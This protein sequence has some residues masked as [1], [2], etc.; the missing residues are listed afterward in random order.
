M[1]SQLL[2]LAVFQVAAFAGA[3]G[4]LLYKKGATGDEDGRVRARLMIL[5]GMILYIG[6]TAL[7]VLAYRLGGEVSILY[8]TYGATFVWGALFARFFSNE[9]VTLNKVIGTSLVIG[10]ICLV[11]L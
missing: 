1:K 5:L 11:T 10:G 7:F 9:K 4:Q 8:P 3:L 6:V 2:P